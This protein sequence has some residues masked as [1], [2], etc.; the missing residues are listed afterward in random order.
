[1]EQRENEL[2]SQLIE[3]FISIG[4]AYENLEEGYKE[5]EE[6]QE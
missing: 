6:I 1:L 5:Y 4:V 2:I 3:I